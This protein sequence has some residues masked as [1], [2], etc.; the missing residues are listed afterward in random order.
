MFGLICLSLAG[1]LLSSAGALTLT[2]YPLIG[3]AVVVTGATITL[4]ALFAGFFAMLLGADTP[5]F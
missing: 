3:R 5:P 1:L 4:A 2:R